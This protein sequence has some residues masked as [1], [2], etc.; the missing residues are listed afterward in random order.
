[1]R[2]AH[3]PSVT[4]ETAGGASL[5]GAGGVW[6]IGDT[7][8]TLAD[9]D[10]P[11]TVLVPTEAVRLLAVDLPVANR[12]KRLAALPFAI[13]DLIAQPLD[14]VH[15]AIGA[16]LA[17][18]RYLVGVVSHAQMRQWLA[19]A[20]AAGL[21]HAAFVPDALALPAPAEGSW[22]VEIDATRAVVR[23]GDGTGF[24]AG[25]SLLPMLWEA[26]GRPRL[27]SHGAPLPAD[28]AGAPAIGP[29]PL[30]PRLLGPALDLRQGSY[31]RQRRVLPGFWKRAGQIVAVGVVAHAG[32]ATADTI[33]LRRI[34]DQRAAETRALVLERAPAANLA[35]DDL[36]GRVADLL[37]QRTTGGGGNPFL[38]AVTRISAALGTLSPPPGVR[39]MSMQS[40]VVTIDTMPDQPP[41]IAAALKAAGIEATVTGNTDG[42]RI[43]V[44]AQ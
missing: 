12:A 24:A 21:E 15:I 25:T 33:A 9:A 11:A 7:G 1:M 41:R 20:E 44:A 37:P 43:A 13:E 14:S 32:I 42:V 10:G 23:R 29:G 30:G 36:A 16:E 18:R 35:G 17:P 4:V 40:G 19:S 28:M 34:A 6:T 3:D 5:S 22:A 39:A 26:A 27:V 38:P 31:A 2:S 8:L